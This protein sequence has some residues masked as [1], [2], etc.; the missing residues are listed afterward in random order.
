M[1]HLKY[2]GHQSEL[3]AVNP[4]WLAE[5]RDKITRLQADLENLSR[6]FDILDGACD[7]WQQEAMER[8]AES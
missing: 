7:Y 4:L 3:V 2:G 5:Q 6:E 8:G 1:K